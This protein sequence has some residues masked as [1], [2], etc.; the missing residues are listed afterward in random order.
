MEEKKQ[1]FEDLKPMLR[2]TGVEH[3]EMKVDP[4]K[5]NG[6]GLCIMNCPFKCMEMDEDKLPK[7]KKEYLCVSCSNCMVACPENALSVVKITNIK[8]GFFDTQ[9]PSNKWPISPQDAQG[10]P[11]EWNTVERVILERRSVRN[12]KKKQVPESLI[13]RVLEAGRFAPSGGNHQPWKF[14]VVTDPKFL[15]ELETACQAFWAGVFPVFNNDETVM[16]MVEVVPTGVFHPITQHGI[17]SVAEKVL[18]VF[19]DAP[20]VIFIGAHP[21]L[22]NPEVSVG[23]CGQNMN[24]AASSLGL[25]VC[26]TNFGGGGANSIPEI[27]SKLGFDEPWMIHTALA[28]GY[29]KFHQAGMVPR[30]ARPITWFRQSPIEDQIK[31]KSSN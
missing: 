6:C 31:L 28:M 10:E 4:E 19:F 12:Y 14:T 20:A 29:P 18:P 1:T 30:H 16:N 8:E 15:M 25:G 26:W 11:D 3:G 27:K 22:N 21:K 9:T 7:M 13:T 24:I 2:P 5:C 17:R 23:I